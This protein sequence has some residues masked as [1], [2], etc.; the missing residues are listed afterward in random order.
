[1]FPS[2]LGATVTVF[3]KRLILMIVHVSV[4]LTAN[5]GCR[6]ST[7][8]GGARD[9]MPDA[10]PHCHT[11]C[12]GG[13]A[14]YGDEV[15]IFAY[16][17]KPCDIPDEYPDMPC[18]YGPHYFCERNCGPGPD[19]RYAYCLDDAYLGV[20]ADDRDSLL[21]LLCEEGAPKHFADRCFSD[22]DCR[23]VAE[24]EAPRLYCNLNVYAC[25]PT[26]RP[27]TPLGFGGDCGITT[28]D[29]AYPQHPI[30]DSLYYRG[31]CEL[32]HL[33]Y[34]PLEGCVRQACTMPCHY[35]EDCPEGTVCL[36]V[37]RG[38][39]YRE[40]FCAGATARTTVAGRTAWLT[41]P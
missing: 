8:G 4:C 7:G 31:T 9:A 23:P 1:M 33:R 28:A 38:G 39:E 26:T 2:G 3:D 15:H 10:D 25:V 35:D 40:R 29:L 12:F 37:V 36:C 18:S 11:D 17:P 22:D 34:D 16:A 24:G 41:C 30:E 21:R 14:C 13:Y 5:S 20:F 6:D 19:H 32:C 27:A